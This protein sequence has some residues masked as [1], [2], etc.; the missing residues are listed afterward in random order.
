MAHSNGYAEQ[1]KNWS[2]DFTARSNGHAAQATTYDHQATAH[3]QPARD[4]R[5]SDYA[6]HAV[7]ETTL[8]V[9]DWTRTWPQILSLSEQSGET[10]SPHLYPP[11][12]GGADSGATGTAPHLSH[13]LGG[14]VRHRLR[15]THATRRGVA[16]TNVVGQ[17]ICSGVFRCG[18]CQS[19]RGQHVGTRSEEPSL[20]HAVTGGGTPCTRR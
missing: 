11:G 9:Y 8:P 16:R 6:V 4:T 2:E 1:C 12:K 17:P 19:T 5:I 18:S 20:A 7:W 13:A 15:V 3:S 14:A 10:A